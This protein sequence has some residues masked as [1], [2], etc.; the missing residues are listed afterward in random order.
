M[1]SD[2][3]IYSTVPKS[4]RANITFSILFIYSTSL[5][6]SFPV[7]FETLENPIDNR[8]EYENTYCGQCRN[9]NQTK[10]NEY[11]NNPGDKPNEC[12]DKFKNQQEYCREYF[13]YSEQ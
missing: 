5:L 4:R 10:Q 11:D 6:V 8:P 7:L 1:N 9:A 13:Q 3:A 2:A 12:F